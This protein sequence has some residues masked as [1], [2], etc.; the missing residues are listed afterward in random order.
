LLHLVADLILRTEVVF[1]AAFTA[2]DIDGGMTMDIYDS[3]AEG[4]Q[5]SA[6]VV[7]FMSRKYQQSQNCKLEVHPR[8][9]RAYTIYS[10]RILY[11]PVVALVSL[12]TN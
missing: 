6:V 8:P 2:Q 12:I 11:A 4:V 1:L 3:M 5:G 10:A 7:C 9:P